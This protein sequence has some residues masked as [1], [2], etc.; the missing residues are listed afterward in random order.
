MLSL[1]PEFVDTDP[2]AEAAGLLDRAQAGDVEAYG[3][4]C[5]LYE[6]RL[7]RQAMVLCRNAALAEDL[8]QDTLVEGWHCLGRYDARRPFFPWLSAILFHRY[9]N[10][11]RERRLVPFSALGEAEHNVV[12]DS[13]GQSAGAEPL[14]DETAEL[15]EETEDCC[16]NAWRSCR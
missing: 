13:I 14:P 10:A 3:E 9:Q 6:D 5:R 2:L 16:G 8:A 15:R 12:Q 1:P 11:M 7:L 4:V